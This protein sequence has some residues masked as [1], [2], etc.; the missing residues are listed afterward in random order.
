MSLLG[1]MLL[2]TLTAA[3]EAEYMIV[4]CSPTWGTLVPA[5]ELI[6]NTLAGSCLDAAACISGR[7]LCKFELANLD[8]TNRAGYHLLL[9]KFEDATNVEVQDLDGARR[10]RILEF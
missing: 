7:D 4:P 5:V 10:R 2:L 6:I 1:L 3:L 8:S 9:H